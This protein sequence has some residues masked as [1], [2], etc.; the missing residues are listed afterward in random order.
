AD[1][2]YNF[3]S[4]LH[5][6]PTGG[7]F[8][9]LNDEELEVSI[10]GERI[11]LLKVEPT[12]NEGLPTGLNLYTGRTSLKAGPHRV[13]S[14]FL[15][16]HSILLDDDIAEIMHTLADTDIGRDREI[17]AYTHLREFEISGPYN[18]TGVSDTPTR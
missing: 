2:E 15:Q 10:D 5:G 9:N 6:T 11:A 4:L 18:V 14:T 8:G 7:L 16:K 12:I 13:T 1:G 17:T 3:R